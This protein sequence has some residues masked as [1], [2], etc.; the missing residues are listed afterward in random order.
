MT[1]A[2]ITK[3]AEFSLIGVHMYGQAGVK[4][5]AIGWWVTIVI[6]NFLSIGMGAQEKGSK[7]VVEIYM[8]ATL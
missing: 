3:Y 8:Y 2:K 7:I 4:Q 5:T 1:E 6:R